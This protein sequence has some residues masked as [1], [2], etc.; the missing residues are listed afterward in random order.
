[1]DMQNPQPERNNVVK[2]LINYQ[3]VKGLDFIKEFLNTLPYITAILNS[4]RQIVFSNN[5]LLKMLNVETLESILGMRTGE[6]INCINYSEENGGCGDFE[7][8]SYCGITK[9]ILISQQNKSTVSDESRLTSVIDG[10]VVSYDFLVSAS[11]LTLGKEYYTIISLND[12]SSEKRRKVLEKIFFHDILNTAG[13]LDGILDIIEDSTD[14]DKVYEFINI[15]KDTSK[16]LIDEILAQRE[17][18]AA[19]QNEL[20]V[21]KSIILSSDLIKDVIKQSMYHIAAKGKVITLDNNSKSI[22]FNTD[23]M[24]L[25]RVLKNMLKN[26]LEAANDKGKV[27]I[28]C[29]EEPDFITFRVNNKGYIPRDIQLQIFQRSFSTKGPNRGLGTYSMRL[30]GEHYLKGKVYFESDQI[31]GTTFFIKLRI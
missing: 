7:S 3:E 20:A 31:E 1:M 4:D 25:K 13:S 10:R 15:A 8:C 16:N 17:L 23:V 11:P 29:Y 26:A 27:V 24:L 19:E 30:L 9:T 14:K 22:S 12:I 28:G 18:L 6:T 5:A 2:E 21:K